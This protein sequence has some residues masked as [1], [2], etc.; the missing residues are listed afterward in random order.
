MAIEKEVIESI[1]RTTDLVALVEAKGIT[2]K[3]NGKSW[4]GLCPFHADKNPS[5]SLNPTKN[6]WQC[7]GCGAAGDVIRFVEL[8]DQVVFKEAVKRL[9]DNGFKRTKAKAAKADPPKAVSVK[10]RKLLARVVA[11]YQHALGQDSR[12]INYLK[13]TGA[14]ATPKA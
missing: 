5:L 10:E 11:H 6:L 9:S 2:L 8:F 1:K 7:F 14:S 3:K 12:G 4:F 13:K